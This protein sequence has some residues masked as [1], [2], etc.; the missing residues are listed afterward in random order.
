MIFNSFFH[1]DQAFYNFKIFCY[2]NI[3]TEMNGAQLGSPVL[4]GNFE[5]CIQPFRKVEHF[6]NRANPFLSIRSGFG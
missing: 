5:I 2:D 6:H 3:I 4:I 1:T